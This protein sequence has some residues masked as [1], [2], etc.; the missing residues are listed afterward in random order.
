LSGWGAKYRRAMAPRTRY[1]R[2]T[3]PTQWELF[4][5]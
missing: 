2:I 5:R 4:R 1:T 3:T